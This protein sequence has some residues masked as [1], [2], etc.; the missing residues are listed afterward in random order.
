MKLYGLFS[1]SY[2]WYE[3]EDLV[4]VSDSVDK[5][6]DY[7]VKHHNGGDEPPLVDECL[8]EKYA[9][10]EYRHFMIKEVEFI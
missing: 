5:L 8:H 1:Y 6:K 2:D 3:W 4:V 7:Y 10:K 9:F